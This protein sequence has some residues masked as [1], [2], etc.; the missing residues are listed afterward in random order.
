[1]IDGIATHLRSFDDGTLRQDI[2][3]NH[4]ATEQLV[5]RFFHCG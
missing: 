1:M 3:N 4:E 2:L 5:R